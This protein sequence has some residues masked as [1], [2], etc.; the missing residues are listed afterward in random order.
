MGSAADNGSIM[1]TQSGAVAP[2][3][4]VAAFLEE[5]GEIETVEFFITDANGIQRGKRVPAAKAQRAARDGIYL[6]RSI[7][8]T[9]IWSGDVEESGLLFELGDPDTPCFMVPGSLR[10]VPWLERPTAQ[11]LLHMVD[12]EGRPFYGDPREV[13]IRV[14]E[15]Y[16]AEGLHPVV[17]TEVEFNLCAARASSDAAPEPPVASPGGQPL[18]ATQMFGISELEELDAFF[19]EVE[20]ACSEQGIPNDTLIAEH[21]PAQYEINLGHVRDPVL[22]ADYTVLLKR[23]IK[24]VAFK[25]GMEATFMAKPYGEHSGNGFHVHMSVCDDAGHNIFASEDPEVDGPLRWAIGGVVANMADSM[26]I[27]APNLNSYRRFVPGS[28]APL[29]PVWGHDNRTLAVRVPRSNAANAR[30]EHRVAGADANPYLV[31]AAV[32]AGAHDGLRHRLDPGPPIDGNAYEQDH[33]P[34]PNVWA[35]ALDRLEAS[36]HIAE[37]FGTDYQSLYSTCKR[38]ELNAF[39]RYVTPLEYSAYLRNV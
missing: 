18:A 11:A 16:R 2:E 29:T 15:R 35:Q 19:H 20:R 37:Y 27:L 7:F 24:G 39:A 21:G 13:L 10:P 14:T 22:A 5:H 4:E 8:A 3:A 6:Q 33:T 26:A 1:R 28:F 12:D 34:L 31:V 9:D 30:L 25:H 17:A 36:A 23:V 38:Q 32:L